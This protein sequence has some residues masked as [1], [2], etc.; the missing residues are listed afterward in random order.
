MKGYS[1]SMVRILLTL[2]MILVLVVSSAVAM[3]LPSTPP[4]VDSTP[5][6]HEEEPEGFREAESSPLEVAV[7]TPQIEEPPLRPMNKTPSQTEGES[8]GNGLGTGTLLL[9]AV[10]IWYLITLIGLLGGRRGSA[11]YRR[12]DS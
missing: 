1:I 11:K 5:I 2:G 4:E 12:G 6:S 3:P 8:V 7:P 10:A 9:I